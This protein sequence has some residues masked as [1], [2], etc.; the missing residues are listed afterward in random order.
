MTTAST[1]SRKHNLASALYGFAALCVAVIVAALSWSLEPGWGSYLT[2]LPAAGIMGLTALVRANDIT[3]EKSEWHWQ[4]RKLGFAMAGI[5]AALYVL[6]PLLQAGF[7][8][9]RSVIV[10]WGVALTWLTTPN[11]PPWA[12]YIFKG[13]H[14][15]P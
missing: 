13:E 4:L 14:H 1:D 6:S 11:Q 12:Q 10:V 9:W 2:S 8:S 5:G 7:P 15:E 3:M